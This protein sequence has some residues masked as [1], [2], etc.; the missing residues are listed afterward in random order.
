MAIDEKKAILRGLSERA[1]QVRAEAALPEAAA[2]SEAARRTADARY[3]TLSGPLLILPLVLA[4]T[5][6]GYEEFRFYGFGRHWGSGVTAERYIHEGAMLLGSGAVLCGAGFGL[7]WLFY[8][9]VRKPMRVAAIVTSI[10]AMVL[11]LAGVCFLG[12]AYSMGRDRAYAELSYKSLADAARRMGDVRA[13]MASYA[14]GSSLSELSTEWRYVPEVIR[15]LHPPQVLVLDKGYALILD[16]CGGRGGHE[17]LLVPAE[18]SEANGERIA[19]QMDMELVS[20]EPVVLRYYDSHYSGED[21]NAMLND[22]PLPSRMPWMMGGPP[23]SMPGSMPG[24][25]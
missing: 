8:D 1:Q 15:S 4:M 22:A 10:L 23:G 6:A 16:D 7:L 24:G 20:R 19:G 13:A 11:P 14:G 12:L 9:V 21:M 17:G 3:R 18:M 2:K 25:R 5:A